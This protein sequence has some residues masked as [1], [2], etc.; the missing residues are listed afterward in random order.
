MATTE[1]FHL[2]VK[3]KRMNL[4]SQPSPSFVR[5]KRKIDLWCVCVYVSQKY[6]INSLFARRIEKERIP[7]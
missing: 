3:Y 7:F 5:I 2:I 6:I 4:S 1:K